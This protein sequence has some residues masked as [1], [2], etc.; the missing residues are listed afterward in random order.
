MRCKKECSL[1]LLKTEFLE[2]TLK[3]RDLPSH[4]VTTHSLSS[5]HVLQCSNHSVSRLTFYMLLPACQNQT[6]IKTV[7]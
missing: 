4:K 3:S 5:C 2:K 6:G 7:D 1:F